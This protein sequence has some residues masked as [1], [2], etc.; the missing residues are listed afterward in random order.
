MMSRIHSPQFQAKVMSAAD[1]AALIKDGDNVGVSG[2]TGSG[3]PKEVPVALAERIT[4]ANAAGQEMR[5]G[6][7]TGAST[8]PE[9]DGALASTGG[10]SFRTPYQSDPELRKAINAGITDYCDI[11]L[12]HSGPQV[13]QG[14]LGNMDVAV[15]EVTAITEDGDLIPSSSIG[16]NNVYLDCADKVI[17]EVNSWQSAD[18]EGMHDVYYGTQLPPNNVPIPLVKPGDRIGQT[19]LRVDPS[20]VIAVVETKDPDR[21]TP[22]KP[23]DE[24]SKTIAGYFLDFLQNEVKQG[25]LPKNLQPLQSG[26]GNIANAVLSGLLNSDLENLTSYTEV[27]QDGMVDLIDAGKLTVASATAFSLS[28]EYADKMND[29]AKFYRQHIVLRPQ[30]ISNNPEP[31]RRL[32][33]IACNGLIE[34]D[35]YGNVNSTHIMGSKMQNGIGGS[36][37]FT[38]N[39]FISCFVT[40]STAKRGDI[41]CIVPMVSHHDHTEHDVMVVITEQGVADLRH[42]APRKRAR[43]IIENCAHPDYKDALLDYLERAE[44]TATS[45]HTP[46]DLREALS[47]H[48]RCLETG[49]MK[50]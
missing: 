23:L 48:V 22:F 29:N 1:A 20:K 6:I 45:L 8:A 11:H 44:K 14:F 7:F 25:R 28:P 26:V 2:F 36:G 40:P 47:W 42:L 43:V 50:A 30:E 32:G 12:S 37:D 5:V 33:V 17:L 31:I 27:I 18:L 49:T 19:T 46:H 3:Y 15:V 13:R 4:A 39:A 38:R 9:L 35:I 34:A 21:N 41:S 24:D 16:N 10:M